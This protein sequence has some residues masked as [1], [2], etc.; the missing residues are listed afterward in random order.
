MSGTVSI[1]GENLILELHGVDRI[2][3]FQRSMT[4]P[5][6]HIVSVSTEKVP[7]LSAQVKSP[8]TNI[9][10]VVKDGHYLATDGW[11]FYEMHN[12]DKCITINLNDDEYKRVVFQVE[13][14]ESVATLIRQVIPSAT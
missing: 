6:K 14:K 5:L 9:P 12:P 1:E 8:G 4:I 7:W 3:A 13:D 2:L 11:V 10:G